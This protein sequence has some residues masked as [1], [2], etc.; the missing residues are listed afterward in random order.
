[1]GSE[2]RKVCFLVRKCDGGEEASRDE[3]EKAL[4]FLRKL[5]RW[6]IEKITVLTE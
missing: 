6:E 4:E 5:E 3:L 1:M 2:L